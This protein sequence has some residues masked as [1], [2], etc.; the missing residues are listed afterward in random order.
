MSKRLD[1]KK[2]LLLNIILLSI[3]Q[4]KLTLLFD[5]N[6][7]AQ[8]KQKVSINLIFV[9][10]NKLA[11]SFDEKLLAQ[12]KQKMLVNLAL[13]LQLVEIITSNAKISRL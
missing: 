7:L 9:F 4:N 2:V 1:Y 10:Q 3:L 12:N 11:L 8:N 13:I 5:K 6:I